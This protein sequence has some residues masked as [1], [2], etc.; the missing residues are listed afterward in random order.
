MHHRQQH[1]IVNLGRLNQR[2]FCEATLRAFGLYK[3]IAHPE[4]E[5]GSRVVDLLR[6][7]R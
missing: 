7:E 5:I 6:L 2:E 1:P 3:V 4:L